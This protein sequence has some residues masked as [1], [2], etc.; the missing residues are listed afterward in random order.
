MK[1]N[2]FILI[3][4][5]ILTA[6]LLLT[7]VCF[8]A[9]YIGQPADVSKQFVP[10]EE[11]E[12]VSPVGDEVSLTLNTVRSSDGDSQEA[13]LEYVDEK[14]DMYVFRGDE[15]I[16]GMLFSADSADSISNS[17]VTLD[18]AREIALDFL[19]D[20]DDLDKY[21]PAEGFLNNSGHYEFN[22][23]RE[24]AG[25]KINSSYSV[26]VCRN[27]EIY[28]WR[29]PGSQMSDFDEALLDGVTADSVREYCDSEIDG[30]YELY[31]T[32]V[33]K[34]DGEY[35]ISC[36]CIKNINTPDEETIR[37]IYPLV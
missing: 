27:G 8:A 18:E 32:I 21:T 35:V 15:L 23:Y 7:G 34:Y 30:D 3:P 26:K 1:H 28:S 31:S 10:A 9:A 11:L 37:V 4:V 24:C 6:V 17:Y 25:F 13:L 36:N 16:G 12:I 2:L 5:G 14:N 33:Q 29:Y 19:A 22:F 20:R